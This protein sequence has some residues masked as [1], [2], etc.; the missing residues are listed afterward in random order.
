M[1][2]K[3]WNE[4]KE[5]VQQIEPDEEAKERILGNLHSE[6]YK[7]SR[8]EMRYMLVA[9]AAAVICIIAAG[10]LAGIFQKN[11]NGLTVYAASLGED[12]WMVL[13][14]GEKKQLQ[15][16]NETA[17]GYVF[18]LETS[19]ESEYYC[20]KSGATVGVDFIYNDENTIEWYVHDDEEYD[21]P[22][23]METDM[24]VYITGENGEQKGKYIL[25]LMKEGK[26]CYVE[27]KNE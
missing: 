18:R 4:M 9:V 15:K 8:A 16:S 11:Q 20:I 27:L 1:D 22:E 2:E 5:L 26:E 13:S 21:F 14:V 23:H 3:T 25:T 24:I 12:E 17:W 10:V 7:K 6:K 19:D